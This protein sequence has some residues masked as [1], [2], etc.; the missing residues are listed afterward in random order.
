MR[1]AELMS[2]PAIACRTHD[3]LEHAAHKLWENDCGALPVLDG[4]GRS[5]AMITDRDICMAAYTRG[6]PLAELLVADA[7]SRR[8]VACHAFDDVAA[9][10]VLMAENQLRRLPVLDADD[11]LVGVLSLNDLARAS[12][13][14]QAIGAQ[15]LR[16]LT[17]VG[18]K[19]GAPAT[20]AAPTTAAPAA[21]TPAMATAAMTSSAAAASPAAVSPA[22]TSTPAVSSAAVSSP[23][24]PTRSDRAS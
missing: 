4:H 12:A 7:M 8:F 14:D 18:R 19:H 13:R 17:G 1:V 24:R 9:A 21:R 20:A 16:A 22:A 15:T 2:S 23:S 10:A 3:T 5:G 11:N 6:R